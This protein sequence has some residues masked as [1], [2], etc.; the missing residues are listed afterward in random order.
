MHFQS[1]SRDAI[2]QLNALIIDDESDICFLLSNI[3]KQRNVDANVACSLSE[4]DQLLNRVIAPPVIFLDNH[5][6]DGLGINYISKLKKTFPTT[7]IVMMTAHDNMSD[8]E[9]AKGEGVDY[10]IGKPFSKDLIFS[11]LDEINGKIAS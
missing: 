1:I 2:N 11:T 9:K 7:K 8:R 6:P 5:L 4:A 3:L 10:F